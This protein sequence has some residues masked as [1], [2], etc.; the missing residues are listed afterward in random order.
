VPHPLLHLQID[1][2]LQK[3]VRM[4]AGISE[5][6][7]AGK[8]VLGMQIIETFA[9]CNSIQEHSIIRMLRSL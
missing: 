3:I 4:N 9:Q 1:Q 5:T 7:K 8:F 6:I 2:K